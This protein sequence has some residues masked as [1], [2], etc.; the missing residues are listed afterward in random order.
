MKKFS[1]FLFSV[2][3]GAMAFAQTRGLNVVSYKGAF[4]PTDSMWTK[5]WTNFD[6]QNAVYNAPTVQVTGYI[7]A[8]TTWLASK[9]YQLNGPVMVKNGAILTIQAGTVI[10]GNAL[11]SNSSLIICRGSKIM[12]LGTEAKPIVFTS[13][14]AVGL[15]ASGDWGGVIIMGNA[16]INPLAGQANI[17]GLEATSDSYYGGNND[18]D[19]SGV[20]QYARIEFGG[21]IFS[22]N[23]EI[24]GLTM[25][26]VGNQTNINHVQCSFIK[27]DAFE[28]F[29]GNVNCSHLVAYRCTDDDFD[30]DFGFSGSVQFCLGL[31]DKDNSDAI[32]G[33]ESNGFESDNDASGTTAK[34]FTKAIFSNVTLVGP[35][36]YDNVT[37]AANTLTTGGA[38]NKRAVFIRRSSNLR[39]INSVFTD[40]K[41]SMHIKDAS[42]IAAYNLDSYYADSSNSAT[43]CIKNCVF[44]SMNLGSTNK[45][46]ETLFTNSDSLWT[47]HGNSYQTSSSNLFKAEITNSN[48]NMDYRPKAGSVIESG[49][50][51]TNIYASTRTRIGPGLLALTVDSVEIGSTIASDTITLTANSLTNASSYTWTVP[52]GVNIISGQGSRTLKVFFLTTTKHAS[53]I[54]CIAYNSPSRVYSNLDSIKITKVKPTFKIINLNN[55]SVV[56]TSN[57]GATNLLNIITVSSTTGLT[58]GSVV[59]VTAGTGVFKT[60]TIVTKVLSSTT[61][62]VS[63]APSTAL[64]SSAV[65]TAFTNNSNLC[66]IIPTVGYSSPVAYKVYAPA[67]TNIVGYTFV[68]PAGSKIRSVGSVVLPTPSQS[69]STYDSTRDVI[70]VIDSITV[71]YDSSFLKG[72]LT[73]TPYNVAGTGTKF[74]LA[75]AKGLPVLYKVTGNAANPSSTVTY[76]AVMANGTSASSYEWTIPTTKVTIKHGA[77]AGTIVGNVITTTVD[78]LTLTFASNFTTG[79]LK[80][81]PI[82]SCGNGL[83]KT[84]ALSTAALTKNGSS[85]LVEI[86]TDLSLEGLSLFP[87]PNNGK[88]SLNMVADNTEEVANVSIINAMGQVVSTVNVENNNGIISADLNN[89]LEQGIYFVKVVVGTEVKIVKISVQK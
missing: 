36:R 42:T 52:T 72:N 70:S 40:Y 55:N 84:F 19:N 64:S 51:F 21:Y 27:D 89:N 20:F 62:Q 50:D 23:N 68:A 43:M 88:F 35:Y 10:R 28:W 75:L 33:G 38:N 66:G 69:W 54:Y 59:V 6:P 31:R 79:S 81:K 17:E 73:V 39:V 56:Y 47:M 4:D 29:G 12:A 57:A 41:Y 74:T 45:G 77:A 67:A 83:I 22:S 61:F 78:T 24:N 49:A 34:P 37:S 32:S 11:S 58:E 8:N 48:Y 46:I 25:G 63:V 44:A 3:F 71:I 76:S 1:L 13:S 80:V 82:N 5:N 9:V 2:L 15:R 53:K 87:N 7:T 65:V 14:K 16:K 85:D 60:N 30:T 86:P 26:G 18:N